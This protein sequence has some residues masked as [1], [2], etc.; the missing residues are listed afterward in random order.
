MLFNFGTTMIT[1]Y[2]SFSLR[3]STFHF[4]QCY[5]YENNDAKP[6]IIKQLSSQIDNGEF[7]LVKREKNTCF[8]FI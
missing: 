5:S 4:L 7:V 6:E 2:Q 3:I 8:D 1:E